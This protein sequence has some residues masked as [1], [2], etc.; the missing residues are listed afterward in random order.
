MTLEEK[1]D[2]ILQY[3]NNIKNSLVS[4]D[5]SISDTTLLE[6]YSTLI[7]SLSVDGA[8]K[9][10]IENGL[11]DSMALFREATKIADGFFSEHSEITSVDLPKCSIVGNYAFLN[12]T[13]LTSVNIPMCESIGYKAFFN[14][15]NL[16]S[17]L[18]FPVCKTIGLSAFLY[19]TTLE[20]ISLPQVTSISDLAFNNCTRL[21]SIEL[22]MATDIGRGAFYTCYRMSIASIPACKSITN[23]MFVSCFNL[24]SLYLGGSSVVPLFNGAVFT[25]TPISG[26][27]KSAGRYGYIYVPSSLYS[28]YLV[29]TNWTYLSSRILSY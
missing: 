14:C 13:G 9:N 22:P 2:L 5:V 20:N 1:L 10:V 17:S 11:A 18:E 16:S 21:S 23:Q 15:Y 19:C 27:S 25:S 8:A 29:S 4:K 24:I 26:Y 6:D 3:K 7:D 12:C 28:Q